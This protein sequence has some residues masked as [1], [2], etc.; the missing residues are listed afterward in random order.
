MVSESARLH[1]E[2]V[3]GAPTEAQVCARDGRGGAGEVVPPVNYVPTCHYTEG[4]FEELPALAPELLRSPEVSGQSWENF[5]KTRSTPGSVKR[6]LRDRRG[7]GVTFLT[8]CLTTLPSKT[9]QTK[10]II[11]CYGTL[12][13]VEHFY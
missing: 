7:V 1:R 11:E 4:I 13:T 6:L 8:S 5:L 9:L 2:E 3:R 12:C 10:I